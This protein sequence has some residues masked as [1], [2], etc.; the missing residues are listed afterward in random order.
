MKTIDLLEKPAERVVCI[1]SIRFHYLSTKNFPSDQNNQ[2]SLDLIANVIRL[3][4]NLFLFLQSIKLLEKLYLVSVHGDNFLKLYVFS[5][6]FYMS[7][8]IKAKSK[9]CLFFF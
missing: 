9:N 4:I 1:P 2:I 7:C 8:R 6:L 5:F 3:L